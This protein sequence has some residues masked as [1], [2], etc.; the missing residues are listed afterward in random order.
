MLKKNLLL[1]V[2][3]AGGFVG[4]TE[5]YGDALGREAIKMEEIKSRCDHIFPNN[6]HYVGTM[7]TAIEFCKVIKGQF[8][9][10][11][12][13]HECEEAVMEAI[14]ANNGVVNGDLC[15]IILEK[16]NL[17]ARPGS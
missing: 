1:L 6:K 9:S 2:S 10:R 17:G 12:R 8:D 16:M 11:A 13:L 5:A 7:D 15:A 4:N 14:A 3:L